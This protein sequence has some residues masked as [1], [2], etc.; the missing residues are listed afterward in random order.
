VP[1][2]VDVPGKKLPLFLVEC[3]L[4]FFF[5]SFVFPP[6]SA[7]PPRRLRISSPPVETLAFLFFLSTIVLFLLSES[8]VKVL[9]FFFSSPSLFKLGLRDRRE[10]TVVVLSLWSSP[11]G[12]RSFPASRR[13]AWRGPCRR[14]TSPSPACPPFNDDF[15]PPGDPPSVLPR[16]RPA[17]RLTFVPETP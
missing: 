8:R 14:G 6:Q 11:A 5:P 16:I 1:T 15:S 17:L 4:S 12:S 10:T 13:S 2:G 3:N 7:F 9:F